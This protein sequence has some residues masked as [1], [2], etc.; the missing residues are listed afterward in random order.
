MKKTIFGTLVVKAYYDED[1]NELVIEV[2]HATNIIALDDNGYSDPFVKVELCPNHKF[3][4]S[5]VCCTKTKHKTLHPIFD[6]TFRFVLGP[7]KSTQKCHEPEVFILFSVYDYN[8]LFSNELV[9]EAILGWSNVREGVLNSNTPVQLHLTC[10]S[11]EE[12]FI[13]HI[14]KGRLDDEDAQEFV[15]KRN[16]VAAKACLKNKRIINESSS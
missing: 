15:S 5:K 10:V 1:T 3:P 7:E 14:L 2:I 13:F 4:A 12:C 9:G 11:D 8:L 16:A 6:E